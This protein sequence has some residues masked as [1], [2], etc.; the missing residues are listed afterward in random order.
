MAFIIN[1]GI[2]EKYIQDDNTTEIIIPDNVEIIKTGA[3]FNCINI[4]SVVISDN[5]KTEKDIF[6]LPYNTSISKITIK[7]KKA[8]VKSEFSATRSEW[9]FGSYDTFCEYRAY[10]DKTF[11]FI[12]ADLSQK[13]NCIGEMK[14]G[15][16]I[17]M[18]IEYNSKKAELLLKEKISDAVKYLINDNDVAGFTAIL[19]L[20]DENNIDKAI[21]Y[22]RN[23]EKIEIEVVLMNYKNEHFGFNNTP[24]DFL[25]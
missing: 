21:D 23:T 14:I 5:T 1:N 25:L 4:K 9:E 12:N 6:Q 17:F 13:E 15:F 18:F 10:I 19:H 20:I 11:D 3:F 8:S 2:L 22:A 24:Y 16:L 7:G